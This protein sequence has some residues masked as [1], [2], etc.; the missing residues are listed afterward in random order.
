MSEDGAEKTI[1]GLLLTFEWSDWRNAQIV[2]IQSVYV[3]PSLRR[4]GVFRGLL[5]HVR[6]LVSSRAD[7]CGVRLYVDNRNENAQSTYRD[8]GMNGEHYRVFEWF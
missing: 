2:W 1:G 8:L 6:Q 3:I 4:Q 7:W 5:D